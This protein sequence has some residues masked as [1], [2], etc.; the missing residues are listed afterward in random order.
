MFVIF[1]E[2]CKDFSKES[3]NKKDNTPRRAI[4]PKFPDIDLYLLLL[5]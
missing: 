3:V 5:L 1:F 4:V 2:I